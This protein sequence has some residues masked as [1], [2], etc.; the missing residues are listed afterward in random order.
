MIE[1]LLISFAAGMLTVLAPCILP[2]LP[3]ILGGTVLGSEDV[4]RRSVKR[5]LVI[6]ASLLISIY[7]FSLLLKATT[8]LLGIPAILWQAVS[9]GI[10]LLF[11]ISILFPSIWERFV[12]ATG[13]YAVTER[14]I[15]MTDK[16][17][18]LI[19]DALLGAALGPIFNSCSP[20]YAL[21]VAVLLPV[22]VTLGMLYLAAYVF[23]LGAI[24]LVVS[25]LGDKIVRRIKWIV[26]P[27]GIFKKVI[28]LSFIVVGIA[29]LVGADKKAQEWILEN[30]LYDPIAG[31]EEKIIPEQ[32]NN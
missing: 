13:I 12:M 31:L 10:V 17:S 2:V 11:G 21:I 27:N 22:S 30:G 4:T 9:G 14:F 19:K 20:T 25:I 32:R 5:P 28:G 29:V 3:V 7:L 6:I 8:L 15:G 16:Q 24:L 18:G 1:L 23:G 26:R